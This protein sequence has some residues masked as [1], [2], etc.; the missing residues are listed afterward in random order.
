[1]HGKLNR[2]DFEFSEIEPILKKASAPDCTYYSIELSEEIKLMRDNNIAESEPIFQIVKLLAKLTSFYMNLDDPNIFR[3][4][5]VIGNSRS[6]LPED[7]D[8]AEQE[9]LFEIMPDIKDAELQARIADVLWLLKYPP[10]LAY[11]NVGLAINAYIESGNKLLNPTYWYAAKDRYE[12][13]FQ[14]ARSLGPQQADNYNKTHTQVEQI[15]DRYEGKDEEI[16]CSS[17]I[18]LLIE[19]S[20]KD[21]SKYIR[22]TEANAL[23]AEAQGFNDIAQQ[24]WELNAK[25]HQ[26][27]KDKEATEAAFR[28]A[29]Y[30]DIAKGI[31]AAQGDLPQF[32]LAASHLEQGILALRQHGETKEKVDELHK[33]LLKYQSEGM[34]QTLEIKQEVDV[35]SEI[36]QRKALV[37]NKDFPDA[38]LTLVRMCY[39][40]KKQKIREQVESLNEKSTFRKLFPMQ[41]FNRKGKTVGRSKYSVEGTQ[42]YEEALAQQMNEQVAWNGSFEANLLAS[43]IHQISIEHN[44]RLSDFDF[45][46]KNNGFIPPG[47][48]KIFAA[49]FFAGMN[50]DFLTASH[51]LIPQVENSFRYL[52]EQRGEITSSFDSTR[53]QKEKSLEETLK[54]SVIQDLFREDLLFVIRAVFSEG[55]NGG[56]N[57]RN[58]LAH[59]LLEFDDFDRNPKFVYAWLLILWICC[60]PILLAL[61]Q[62]SELDEDPETSE[63]CDEAE[64]VPL[65]ETP[66]LNTEGILKDEKI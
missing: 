48:E 29:A 31:K 62:A 35:T 22:L 34:S 30:Q 49:G 3:A 55:G 52:L 60:F 41:F 64:I 61:S 14:L 36:H 5:M 45:I 58:E 20:N 23:D 26:R 40:P 56:L 66:I 59:G 9:F 43:A 33:L 13:A 7:L 37:S 24:Y 12:R 4:L 19:Y 65:P 51:I 11:K 63:A 16:P 53:I 8:E 54:H 27:A 46:V 1:M 28:K 32:M 17:F 2:S 10:R 50:H 57:L 44:I 38:I 39:L 42:E 15:I 6:G 47:R 25:L 18:N 21:L